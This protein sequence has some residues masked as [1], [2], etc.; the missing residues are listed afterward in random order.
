M[1]GDAEFKLQSRCHHIITNTDMISTQRGAIIA[2]LLTFFCFPSQAEE[3]QILNMVSPKLKEFLLEHSVELKCLT[4]AL[5]QAF[6]DRKLELF[7][8]YSDDESTPRSFQSYPSESVVS[9]TIRENQQPVDQFICLLYEVMNS[10]SEERVGKL[11]RMAQ[12][13]DI[14]RTTFAH[15]LL[16]ME[17]DTLKKTRDLIRSLNFSKKDIS[18]SFYYE[19][20]MKCPDNF[21]AFL[22]YEKTLSSNYDPLANYE[23]EYDS[24]ERTNAAPSH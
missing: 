1:D 17:F 3:V 10:E 11:C 19:S 18:A 7:Y 6:T 21:E 8:Y 22:T 13:K 23:L 12:T 16:K 24:L 2:L 14:S 4:N 20:F 5:S 15:D 9:I